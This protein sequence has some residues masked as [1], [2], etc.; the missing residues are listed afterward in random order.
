MSVNPAG[1][2]EF[3]IVHAESPV[4]IF[5]VAKHRFYP[6]ALCVQFDDM[7]SCFSVEV[8]DEKPGFVGFTVVDGNEP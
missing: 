3:Y 5:E 6:H 7:L 2:G 4:A 1:L 8:S